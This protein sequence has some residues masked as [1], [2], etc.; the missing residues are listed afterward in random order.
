MEVVA[1]A[2]QR[3]SCARLEKNDESAIAQQQS[4][5]A[6]QYER[7][8]A[9]QEVVG[10]EAAVL[11][12]RTLIMEEKVG[13]EQLQEHYNHLQDEMAV[14]EAALHDA[15]ASR[16]VQKKLLEQHEVHL[17][18][19]K[20][21]QEWLQEQWQ[22]HLYH[23]QKVQRDEERAQERAAR[24]EMLEA[25]A[26]ACATEAIHEKTRLSWKC[27]LIEDEARTVA[28][29]VEAAAQHAIKAEAISQDRI[30]GLEER[31]A[32]ANAR[33][34]EA[35]CDKTRWE[36]ECELI[37]ANVATAEDFA[38]RAA[39]AEIV[40][41]QRIAGLE[42][43]ETQFHERAEEMQRKQVCWSRGYDLLKKQEHEN[44]AQTE[45]ALRDAVHSQTVFLAQIN[46][47][48]E[49][50]ARAAAHCAEEEYAKTQWQLE[51]SMLQQKAQARVTKAEDAARHA[52]RTEA[53]IQC[54]LDEAQ[55]G[56][57]SQ[58]EQE[59]QL[60]RESDD[61]CE[62]VV[63]TQQAEA[64]AVFEIGDLRQ[65]LQELQHQCRTLQCQS[66]EDATSISEANELLDKGT[67]RFLAL[68]EVQAHMKCRCTGL[69]E[70]V[71]KHE[72]AEQSLSL[73]AQCFQR[74]CEQLRELRH[75]DM[76][77]YEQ[78]SS[79]FS[80]AAVSD[81]EFGIALRLESEG[82]TERHCQ[83]AMLDA[84]AETS[85]YEAAWTEQRKE[86]EEE[87]IRNKRLRT[88]CDQF[89]GA[90]AGSLQKGRN[91]YDLMQTHLDTG[92]RLHAECSR[93]EMEA[94]RRANLEQAACMTAQEALQEI[95]R[96]RGESQT[97]R[98]SSLQGRVGKV[99]MDVD[100]DTTSAG[101]SLSSTVPFTSEDGSSTVS[102][103]DMDSFDEHCLDQRAHHLWMSWRRRS[104][105]V[106][107]QTMLERRV[108]PMRPL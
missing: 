25:Q 17:H 20:Q 37:E 60:R 23:T 19:S 38:R 14:A 66:S 101:Q 98:V 88:R 105:A 93:W 97:L 24:V 46:M 2:E 63:N 10:S 83:Q 9:R 80:K 8:T 86:L 13:R 42:E 61:L 106:E 69:A 94:A 30:V 26:H 4:K 67:K 39:A 107:A 70:L 47:W 76:L 3:K 27:E 74:E 59:A 54:A 11:Q 103:I 68:Q 57:R 96:L 21:H 55:H 51:C 81:V 35:L 58:E 18:E 49:G 85:R 7:E 41:E 100:A 102:D 77:Q 45:D 36:S 99:P 79:L 1:A 33:V 28:A 104:D 40:F 44:V 53:V 82:R 64:R 91:S 22:M 89:P 34:S 65:Q 6:I 15:H 12:A 43:M 90:V 71:Q 31:E 48:Q 108:L 5:A 75:A 56:L 52:T 92:R 95:S 29:Q 84:F 50:E 78:P 87:A 32:H 72:E 73:K 62:L 16:E